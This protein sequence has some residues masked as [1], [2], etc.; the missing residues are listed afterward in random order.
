MTD[1]LRLAA[2]NQQTAY[3][4]IARSKIIDCWQAVGAEINLIGSLKTGLLMKHRDIDFHIYTPTLD[5]AQ[6]FKAV[7]ALAQ[8][9]HIKK[10]TYDNL[11]NLPDTCLEWHAWYETDDGS[12]W[13][14]DMIHMPKGSPFDGYF[15]KIAERISAVMSPAQKETILRLKYQTPDNQ[16]IPGIMYYMAVLRDNITEYAA[17]EN[18][19]Q[20]NKTDG[21]INWIP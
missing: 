15:E 10:V 1:I 4:I 9:P 20:Q 5:I 12:L 19:L 3:D 2:Q 14:I 18:W 8:N 17:F 21:I 6:S 11:L 16:K 7:S 13:Q